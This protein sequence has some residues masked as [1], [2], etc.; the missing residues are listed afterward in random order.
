[1]VL[2][3]DLG[4]SSLKAGI[5]SADGELIAK[6]TVPYRI[7]PHIGE[8]FPFYAREWEFAFD[9][10]LKS[11]PSRSLSALAL[12]GNGPTLLACDNQGEP[13]GEVELWLRQRGIRKKNRSSYY[14]PKAKWLMEND[15]VRREKT[16]ILFSCPE[17]L[18]FRLTGSKTMTLPHDSF[19]PYIWDDKQIES[20][21]LNRSLF[22]EMV[23]MGDI[24]GRIDSAASARYG[25]P[26]GL[27]V[28][29]VGS[30]FMASLLGSGAV[31][32]GTVCDRAGT[33]EGINY[34]AARPSGDGRL[35]DLPHVVEPYWNVAAILSSTGG[36]LEW[37]RYL[38]GQ[39]QVD[40]G[41]ILDEI[42]RVPAARPAP[43]FFPG[44]RG[45]KQWEFENGSFHRLEPRH[46]RAEM[47][48][49]VLEAIGFAVRRGIELLEGAGMEVDEMRVTGG[50]A[51]GEV[52]NQMK[53]D[54]CGKRLLTTKIEDA[55]LAGCACC[56]AVAL[57]RAASPKEATGT[58]V[59]LQ[60]VFEPA[61]ERVSLYN[62]AYERYLESA[63]ALL[64][65][66]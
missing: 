12:S 16:R 6:V 18:Q 48:R 23:R 21:G 47:G 11:L 25:L 37:Y 50:Q 17:W 53:A 61:K 29:A 27:P 65:L 7:V 42:S 44:T 56:A 5:L 9:R 20:Y 32:L 66:G 57:G 39:E 41:D 36:V 3:A 31:E 45:D 60:S 28:V 59:K 2:A 33:S 19:R 52:W 10:A 15:N 64:R 4:T 43:L 54:I 62:E 49:A 40:Y 34:C 14:L 8:E 63:E 24:A 58:Y 51:R 1:M 38:T 22:P 30:D 13:L 46:G 26:S 35:R 55:E